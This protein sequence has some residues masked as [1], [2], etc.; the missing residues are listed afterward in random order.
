[1]RDEHRIIYIRPKDVRYLNGTIN[2]DGSSMTEIILYNGDRFC[3]GM[4]I[5][6]VRKLISVN[7]QE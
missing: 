6:D 4:N 7:E 5:H 2:D 3:T 1:M